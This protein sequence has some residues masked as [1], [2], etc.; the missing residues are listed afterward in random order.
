MKKNA[1]AKSDLASPSVNVLGLSPT[2]F[3]GEEDIKEIRRILETAGYRINA[4]PGGGSAWSEIMQL[5]QADFFYVFFA[6]KVRRGK[7]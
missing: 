6:P 5:P 3:R 1:K 2:Y 7:T 4:I